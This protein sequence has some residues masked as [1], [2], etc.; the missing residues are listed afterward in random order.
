LKGFDF[1]INFCWPDAAPDTVPTLMM[2]STIE[3]QTPAMCLSR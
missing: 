3:T 2:D 1:V